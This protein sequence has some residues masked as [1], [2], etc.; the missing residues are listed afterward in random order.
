MNFPSL[1]I[2]GDETTD[3]MAAAPRA[4]RFLVYLPFLDPQGGKGLGTNLHCTAL[5]GTGWRVGADG[6][7]RVDPGTIF[8]TPCFAHT[9][10]FHQSLRRLTE[11]WRRGLRYLVVRGCCRDELRACCCRFGGMK[12]ARGGSGSCVDGIAYG[13]AQQAWT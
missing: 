5:V 11:S 6:V 7:A 8:F 1:F 2:H 9:H 10:L 13:R 4:N 12:L 3:S